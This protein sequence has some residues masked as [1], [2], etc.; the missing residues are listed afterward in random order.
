VTKPKGGKERMLTMDKKKFITGLEQ[1]EGLSLR[2]ISRRTGHHFNTVKKYVDREDWNEATRQAKSKGSKLDEYKNLIDQW[3]KDDLNAK[4]KQRHTAR[5]VYGR[6]CEKYENKLDVS[7][8]TVA[9]YVSKMKEELYKEEGGYLPLEHP[10]GEAQVDF[11]A[12]EFIE[13]GIKYEG[14]YLNI[15]FPYSNGGYFQIFKGENQECLLEGMKTIFKHIDCVPKVIWFDNLSAA[16]VSI[17]GEGERKLTEGFEKFTLHYRY[18][19][20]FCNPNAGHD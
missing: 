9:N 3:L 11:G 12:V 4:R 7:Y 2:E 8:R 5:R 19:A 10:P 17:K 18:R 13:K 6:L 15:S 16:V 1:F 14:H 20:V